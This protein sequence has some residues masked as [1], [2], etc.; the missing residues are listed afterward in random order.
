VLRV[1]DHPEPLRELRRLLALEEG[2][3]ALTRTNRRAESARAGGLLPDAEALL[4]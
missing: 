2:Y 3:R 1:D 4:A